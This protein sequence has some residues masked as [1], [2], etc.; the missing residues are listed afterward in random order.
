MKQNCKRRTFREYASEFDGKDRLEYARAKDE[1]KEFD[2]PLDKVANEYKETRK[3]LNGVPLIEAARFYEKH[4][5]RGINRNSVAAADA[6]KKD[7][8]TQQSACDSY[9][10]RVP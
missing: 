3:L 6:L 7:G 2:L 9:V 5:L 1:L 4:N 10:D 8:K